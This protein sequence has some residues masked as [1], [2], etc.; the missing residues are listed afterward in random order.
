MKRTQ[1]SDRHLDTRTALDHLEQR[2]G[3]AERRAVEEH[4]GRPCAACREHLRELGAL[5]ELIRTDNAPEV[6][7]WLHARATEVFVPQPQLSR[8]QR[9]L[10]ALATLVFDS[11]AEPLPAAARRSVGEARRLTYGL[12]QHSLEI[13]LERESS[14]TV[15][16]RGWL[17]VPDA[18]LYDITLQV[19]DETRRIQPDGDGS[20]LASGLPIGSI[21]IQVDGPGGTWQLPVIDP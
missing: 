13:E 12:E 8:V 1:G 18:A 11:L 10:G 15:S 21:T 17:V 3:A 5:L 4:L 6:P 19:A 16:L 7:A 20:F 2:L 14:Q 9:A